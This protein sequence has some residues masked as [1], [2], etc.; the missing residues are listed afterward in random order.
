MEVEVLYLDFNIVV[1]PVGLLRFRGFELEPDTLPSI[2]LLF[3]QLS[4][5]PS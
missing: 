3:R 5:N 2:L 4:E 1:L